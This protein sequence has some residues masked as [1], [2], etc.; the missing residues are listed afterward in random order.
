MNS[1]IKEHHLLETILASSIK[2]VSIEELR[3]KLPEG[4][5]INKALENLSND[6][7]TRSLQLIEARGGWAIR[8]RPEHSDFCKLLLKKPLKLTSAALETLVVIAYFQPVTRPEIERIRGVTVGKSIIDLLLWSELIRPGP[9][10]QSPGNPLTFIATN[11]FLHQ[12][13]L[14]SFDDLPDINKLREEGVLNADRNI[15]IPLSEDRNEFR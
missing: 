1:T 7:E 15:N 13:N 9:R 6:Y 5:N 8:T 3:E 4:T 11:K 14:A 2:P 10:R 12:F